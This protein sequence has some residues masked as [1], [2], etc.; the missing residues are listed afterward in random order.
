MAETDSTDATDSTGS[1]NLIVDSASFEEQFLRCQVCREK[2]DREARPPKSLPCNHTFCQPCLKQVF[3]HGQ[4]ASRRERPLWA[5]ENREGTLKC[6]TCRVEIYLSRS[7][8]K[9]LPSDHR[10]I[11]M[12]DFMAQAITKTQN[13]CSKHERQP[14]NFF[15]RTCLLPVCRD[16]TVLD[17]KEQQ[18]HV[19]VDVTD[20]L[21]ETS[22]EFTAL[23]NKSRELL[24]KMKQRSDSLA[25]GSKWLDIFERKIKGEIKDTFIEYRL[26]LERRQDSQVDILKKFIKEQKESMRKR[27]DDLNDK[28][29]ELQKLYDTFKHAR[30]TNDV[31]QL[32]TI[33][34]NIQE[35]EENFKKEAETSDEDLYVSYKFEVENE[36]SF[37]AEM[38]G[39]GEVIS[40]KDKTISEPVPRHQLMLFDMEEQQDEERRNLSQVPIDCDFLS[41]PTGEMPSG[42]SGVS[43]LNDEDDEEDMSIYPMMDARRLTRLIET[44]YPQFNDG[45]SSD[46]SPTRSRDRHAGQYGYRAILTPDNEETAQRPLRGRSRRSGSGSTLSQGLLTP[47]PPR[48]TN[49]SGQ[50]NG[51]RSSSGGSGTGSSRARHSNAT[52][53]ADLTARIQNLLQASRNA[54]EETS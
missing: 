34:Q 1:R 37:L 24:D 3:D 5:G 17:H 49:R 38:S 11:Q 35:Q 52:T 42:F 12:I 4:P 41:S 16:C 50:S 36:G 9:K 46:N 15:C 18:G 14:I 47:E 40:K 27:F 25:N 13:S 2:Y 51:S 26:L 20:A 28:G 10:V 45:D 19:I 22:E 31:R 39:L 29:T 44:E 6:P 32:F 53:T 21:N 54:Q 7:E 30:S 48:G 33:N 43:D 8:I 23:E